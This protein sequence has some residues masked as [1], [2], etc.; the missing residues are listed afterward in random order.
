MIWHSTSS[1]TPRQLT[2][3][4]ASSSN[5]AH[6]EFVSQQSTSSS[7]WGFS[8]YSV[9]S[10]PPLLLACLLAH[11]PWPVRS[12][13][14]RLVWSTFLFLGLSLAFF[15][16]LRLR[17]PSIRWFYYFTI[18]FM[19]RFVRIT[20]HVQISCLWFVFIRPLAISAQVFSAFSSFPALPL[21]LAG[22]GSSSSSLLLHD[23]LP[24]VLPSTFP[25]NWGTS[26]CCKPNMSKKCGNLLRPTGSVKMIATCRSVGPWCSYTLPKRTGS[27]TKW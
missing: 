12:C 21:H 4:S 7:T 26:R 10:S 16:P 5:R 23:P 9:S 18:I 3:L 19:I 11:A 1:V 25:L 15:P 2:W 14:P 20:S 17:S 24:S 6:V 22:S 27:R 13:T 8:F